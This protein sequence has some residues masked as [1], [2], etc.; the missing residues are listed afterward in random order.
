MRLKTIAVYTFPVPFK[1]V[2]RHASASRAKT[3]NLIVAARSECGQVGYGEGCPRNYV[4]GETVAGGAAF[5]RAVTGD[6]IDK[7]L[8]AKSLRAWIR[9]HQELI[10][11]NP[12][13]FCAI[14]IAILDLI[15]KV[16]QRP[17]EQVIGAPELAGG[18]QYSAIL[19]DAPYP[20]YWWQFQ[21]Y[22]RRGFRDFKIKLFG[23]ALRDQRKID[24]FRKRASAVRLRL[25]AN[26]LWTSAEACI[27]HIAGLGGAI[28]AIEE[29]LAQGD[30]EGFN[31]V[32]EACRAKIILDE[33]LSRAGQLGALGGADRWLIN[34]RVSKMGGIFRSL[35]LAETAAQAGIG[36]IVG[37]QV[38][39]TSIL[40]RAALTVMNT[41]HA[42][43]VAAEGAFGTHLL[44]RDLTTPC[45]MFGDRGQLDTASMPSRAKPGLGLQIQELALVA[46]NT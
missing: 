33:S 14:E 21:R 20:V 36:I 18:L 3:E 44:K 5:I 12:A 27:A 10:D 25:D 7:V 19:G 39:E 28:F 17:L 15:G 29:P 45:L 8:D 2:F 26:N 46:A 34:L 16:E 37:A 23:D 4:T 1:V 9:S 40:T 43:L 41:H 42:N 30:L 11:L 24:L 38:G 35:D 13:A 22:W 31:R 6:M 32:G